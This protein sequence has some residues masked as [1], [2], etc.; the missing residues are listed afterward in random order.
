M[1]HFPTRYASLS[2]P[3]PSRGAKSAQR[4]H[5]MSTTPCSTLIARPAIF[6]FFRRNPLRLFFQRPNSLTLHCCTL[7]T[8]DHCFVLMARQHTPDPRTPE[9]MIEGVR[10]RM[11]DAVRLR[12]RADVPIGIYLSGGIDSSVIAGMVAHLV[13]EQNVSVGSA[14]S[15]SSRIT[16]FSI[17]F[18]E[19]SGYDESAIANRTAEHLGVKYIKKLM[20]EAELANRFED[21][22]WHCEQHNADLNFVGKFALSEVPQEEG[23]KVVLTGEGADEIFAGYPLYLPDYLREPDRAG[24]EFNPLPEKERKTQLRSAEDAVREHYGAIGADAGDGSDSVA[25]RML[26]GISTVDSMAAFQPDVFASWTETKHPDCDAQTTI[27]SSIDGL[28]RSH[29]ANDWHPLHAALYVWSKGHLPN[30][31][32]TC[33]GDRTE[34]AHSIEARTPFLDHVLTEY[35]NRLPPSV[36][37]RWLPDERRF[38]EKWILREAARP[39]ITE[40]LY[41]RKKH[42]YSAPT[43]WPKGGALYRLLGGLVTEA[44]VQQLGFVAWEK[45][46]GLV[47][48]AFGEKADAR[49]LRLVLVVAEWVVL[50]KRFGVARARP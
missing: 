15:A 38:V 30:I 1:L 48:E 17:A 12:L 29:I 33:L 24:E 32:L 28:A 39:F 25:R 46:G 42:P 49:A 44:N 43:T 50:S 20:N 4:R 3:F 35:V 5:I 40:E 41:L 31:F 27:A 37:L 36:K 23:Y 14:N 26:N 7:E 10:S 11:L 16:C 21:A 19:S 45:V 47:E 2:K 18:E 34:M 8:P 22:V 6:V 13:R 9:E